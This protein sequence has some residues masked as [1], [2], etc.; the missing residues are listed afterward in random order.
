MSGQQICLDSLQLDQF[1]SPGEIIGN[2]W[3]TRRNWRRLV[4]ETAIFTLDLVMCPD[5]DL[6][7]APVLPCLPHVSL[8][9]LKPAEK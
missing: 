4:Q 7:L 8:L 6:W 9:S 5:F 1:P 3:E 2:K